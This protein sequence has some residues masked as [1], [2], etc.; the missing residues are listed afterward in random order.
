MLV[1]LAADNSPAWFFE[2]DF[3][4]LSLMRQP[5]LLNAENSKFEP[6]TNETNEI[7]QNTV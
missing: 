7:K 3:Q 4:G 2:V 5:F 1:S 6:T